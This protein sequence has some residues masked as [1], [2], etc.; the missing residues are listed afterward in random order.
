MKG[1][2]SKLYLGILFDLSIA[3]IIRN[4]DTKE[5]TLCLSTPF[6]SFLGEERARE[7]NN[8]KGRIKKSNI[9]LNS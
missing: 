2:R 8:K 5:M 3:D 7:K 9:L 1:R 6:H 4:T